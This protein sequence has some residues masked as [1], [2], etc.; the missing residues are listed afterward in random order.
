MSLRKRITI[1]LVQGE[2]WLFANPKI[3]LGIIFAITL[4]FATRVGGLRVS[5]DFADE[6]W[7]MYTVQ[8][9]ASARYRMRLTASSSAR[10]GRARP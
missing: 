3:V 10:I 7:M 6:Q 2:E 1:A 5:T 9:A 4:V 8:S